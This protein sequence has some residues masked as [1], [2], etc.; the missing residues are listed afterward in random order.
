VKEL[1]KCAKCGEE[2]TPQDSRCPKCG[3]G[4]RNIY[5]MDEGKAHD[6]VKLKVKDTDGKTTRISVFRNKVSNQGKEAKEE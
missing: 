3:S 5:L 2:L 4:D 6:G 1:L